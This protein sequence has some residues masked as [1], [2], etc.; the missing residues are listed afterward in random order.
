MRLNV[1]SDLHLEFGITE[2]PTT[3]ADV[4]VLAGDIHV[5][6]EGMQWIQRQFPEQHVVYVL[7]NH[8]F[9]HQS[10]PELTE[11]LKRETDGKYIHLLENDAIEIEGFTF[12]GCTLWTDFRI[13]HDPEA[14]ML[15]ANRGISDFT[16][17]EVASQNRVLHPQDTVKLNAESVAWLKNELAKRDRSKAIVVT[18]HAPSP[19]SIPPF[20]AGNVLN[21]AFACD[22][23]PL[24]E[25]TTVPLWI[26]GHTHFNVD[27]TI[28]STRIVS[29]QRGYPMEPSAGYD[30]RFIVEI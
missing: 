18:H 17:I 16:V 26:H 29:N 21:A 7:G 1:L 30:A 25:S 12:L 9:Y 22:L 3:D 24:I 15:A 10:I 13:W 19:R 4:V 23:E 11:R 8:E 20:H 2:L 5:G 27:Y 28:G 14:A 6:R